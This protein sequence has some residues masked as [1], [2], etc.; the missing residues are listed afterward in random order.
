MGVTAAA[1]R[2]VPADAL[3]IRSD[4][5]PALWDEYATARPDTSMYHLSRWAGVMRDAFGH[6]TQYLAALSGG[7]V[8]GILPLVFFNT[9][10]FGRFATSAPY[11]K[12]RVIQDSG[13]RIAT[14]CQLQRMTPLATA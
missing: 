5:S 13:G 9:P 11:Q 12:F 4:L 8:A 3:E 2:P 1:I 7:R 14:A 10:L 6:R